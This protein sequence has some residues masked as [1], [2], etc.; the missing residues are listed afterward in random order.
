MKDY[1]DA[2]AKGIG[3]ATAIADRKAIVAGNYDEV[4]RRAKLFTSQL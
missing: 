3:V 2:G 1:L 4:T